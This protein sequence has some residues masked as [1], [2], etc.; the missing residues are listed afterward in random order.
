MTLPDAAGKGSESGGLGANASE[1]FEQRLV[2]LEVREVKD[3]KRVGNGKATWRRG[4]PVCE[5][6]MSA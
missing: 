2:G 5:V 1:T 6:M 4:F 3:G